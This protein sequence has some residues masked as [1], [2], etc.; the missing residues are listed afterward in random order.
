MGNEIIRPIDE[1]TAKAVQEVSRF[2]SKVADASIGAGG[3]LANVFGSL[4]ANLVGLIGDQVEYWRRRRWIA[5]NADIEQR[6]AAR[7]AVATEPSPTLAIPL[8]EAAVD[9]TRDEL[10]ELWT[11]LLTNAFDPATTG[12][13]RGSFI[14]TLKAFDPMDAVV[15]DALASQPA[16]R[17]SPNARDFVISKT[18]ISLSEVVLS[19]EN[20]AQ[21][22]CVSVLGRQPWD[23]ILT[24]KGELLYRALAK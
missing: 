24:T 13:V 19:L 11:R 16:N 20:L 12:K 2:G 6:L 4:P 1:E 14:A 7:G 15:F 9:E 10:K 8:F 17:I 21:L 22:G 23:P 3:Y 5:L 18:N